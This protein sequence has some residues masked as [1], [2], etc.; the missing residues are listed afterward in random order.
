R[1]SWASRLNLAGEMSRR[2]SLVES[3]FSLRWVALDMV[4]SW[5]LCEGPDDELADDIIAILRSAPR[6]GARKEDKIRG[7]QA[8]DDVDARLAQLASEAR[9]SDFVT[10]FGSLG[11][12]RYSVYEPAIARRLERPLSIGLRVRGVLKPDIILEEYE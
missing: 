9:V 7:K 1:N 6:I 5:C 2:A 8:V 10:R 3:E 12:Q 11:Q 4:A